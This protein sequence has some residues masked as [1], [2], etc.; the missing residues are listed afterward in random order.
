M[1]PLPNVVF[2]FADE[3]R[4]QATGYNGAPNC[5]TPSLDALAARSV[6]VTHAVAGT[7][8]C[9]PY[10][11]SLMTG[12]YPLTHGVYINDVELAPDC[13][14]IARAFGD[15]GYDTAYIGKWHLYALPSHSVLGAPSL[16]VAY[17]AGQFPAAV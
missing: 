13:C 10:R 11:A 2:I 7:P 3:W 8:V 14:S 12:Q 6:N 17:G 4:A 16:P 1:P 15:S 9:S 5:D